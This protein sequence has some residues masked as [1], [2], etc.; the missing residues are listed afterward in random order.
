MPV[1]VFVQE[2]YRWVKSGRGVLY[3]RLKSFF[4]F[5]KPSM[6]KKNQLVALELVVKGSLDV[7]IPG[8]APVLHH[9]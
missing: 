8:R 9:R 5:I 6:W 1:S 7:F 3:G 2:Q 4:M